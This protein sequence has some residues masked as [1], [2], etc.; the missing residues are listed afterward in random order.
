MKVAVSFDRA[1]DYIY[2][3]GALWERV[4]F[5]HLFEDASLAHIHQCL[6]CYKN[7]DGGWGHGIEPDIATPDS[8]PRAMEFALQIFRTTGIS[9]NNLFNDAPEWL[10]SHRNADGSLINPTRL[11][12]YPCTPTWRASCGQNSP[13]SIV[14]NLVRLGIGTPLVL[15]STSQ[16]VQDNLTLERIQSN[17]VLSLAYETY[18]YFM[19]ID[20]F[21]RVEVYRKAVIDN[22][23]ALAEAASEREYYSFFAFAP[24]PE[25]PVAKATPASLRKRMLSYLKATQ[26]ADGI[27]ENEQSVPHWSPWTTLVVMN[28]LR[29]YGIMNF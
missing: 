25:T 11:L 2:S 26:T 15:D 27:W 17:Y 13:A 12:D 20:D 22:I 10:E 7:P 4:L 1:R 24:H 8:H 5:R 16:W 21:P 29:H 6:A 28:A 18:D 19:N 23:V 3:N 14:G 9:A